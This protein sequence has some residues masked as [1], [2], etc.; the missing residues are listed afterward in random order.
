MVILPF[1]KFYHL[2]YDTKQLPHSGGIMRKKSLTQSSIILTAMLFAVMTMTLQVNAQSAYDDAGQAA[3]DGYSATQS[4]SDE[5][6]SYYSGQGFDTPS[7]TPPAV[8]LR[9]IDNPTPQLLRNEDGSN[10]YTPQQYRSLHINEPPS[11]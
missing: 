2:N 7:E 6:A 3:D 5:N 4:N 9:G 1:T 10:P 11:P 8:D